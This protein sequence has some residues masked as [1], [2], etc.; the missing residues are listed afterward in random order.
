MFFDL[1]VPVLRSSVERDRSALLSQLFEH[2]YDC[3]A[4]NTI[5]YGR[6]PKQHRCTI[7]RIHFDPEAAS[8]VCS[9]RRRRRR[10]F[11]EPSLLRA[12]ARGGGAAAPGH[13]ATAESGPDQVSRLTVVLESPADAQSLT[14]GSEALQSYDVVAAVPCCQRSF[15]VLCKDSDVDV[16]S[17]PSGK[18]LPFNI[19][20]KNTDA[21]LSRGA[22]FEVTYSQAIQNSSN[23][24]FLLA[25]C[26]ALLT[27]TRGRG[28][29]LASGAETWLNCRS[30]HD[31]ANL[32][33]LLGLSQEQS[34]RAVSDTPLAVL[35]RAEARKGRRETARG[36]TLRP[37]L[38]ACG[39][40][41]ACRCLFR[42]ATVSGGDDPAPAELLE[43]LQI[44][45]EFYLPEAAA[46]V[47]PQGENK[48]NSGGQGADVEEEDEEDDDEEDGGFLSF[49]TSGQMDVDP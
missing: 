3:V 26:E 12:T 23:R 49:G 39:C 41:V 28:I 37:C 21:A 17:L 19:N 14:A 6:L 24:R 31:V 32:G 44:P 27:F 2:G 47:G 10:T 34:L 48:G 4:L 22:V 35:R 40:F 8:A 18:R 36:I 15:E 38:V 29:L 42:G 43:S 1:N 13:G 5:V 45:K 9:R 20:K 46:V 7:E 33:Q 30:P 25:N 16:I 11:R